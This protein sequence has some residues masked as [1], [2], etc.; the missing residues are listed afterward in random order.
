MSQT[1]GTVLS[2]SIHTEHARGKDEQLVDDYYVRRVMKGIRTKLR[3]PLS[4]Y[5]QKWK[6]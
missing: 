2:I 3:M 1:G 6:C 4:P 5:L